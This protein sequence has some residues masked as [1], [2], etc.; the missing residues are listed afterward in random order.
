MNTCVV[1]VSCCLCACALSFG[2]CSCPVQLSMYHMGMHL[3]MLLL[4]RSLFLL[5]FQETVTL[6]EEVTFS[7]LQQLV[8]NAIQI[9]PQN[10]K[11]RLGFPP[12]V[13]SAP[14]PGDTDAVVPLNH[15]DKISV[16]STASET[17]SMRGF[18]GVRL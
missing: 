3:E 13:L 4:T 1:C 10:Q 11:L 18:G 8:F 14:A 16:E 7:Q 9:P 15:G 2:L 12:K 5:L 6:T 17:Q